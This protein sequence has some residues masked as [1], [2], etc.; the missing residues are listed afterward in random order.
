[1]YFLHILNQR[2]QGVRV[3]RSMPA[4]LRAT[5]SQGDIEY[6]V[7]RVKLDRGRED[8]VPV[9]KGREDW[10]STTLSRK[11]DFAAGYLSR[12][13]VG[14][15]SSKYNSSGTSVSNFIDV[16][17]DF[18]SVKDTDWEKV[19][20]KRELSSLNEKIE[21]AEAES[22]SRRLGLRKTPTTKSALV[23]HELEQMLDFKRRE[24]RRLKSGEDIEQSG[25]LERIRR[26]IQNFKEQVDTLESHL[27]KRQE[28]L[29][30]LQRSIE[31]V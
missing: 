24:L 22:R 25:N 8:D 19:R 15:G 13:G 18:S 26:E 2:H 11:D 14:E 3:P 27:A 7:E 4:S 31:G 21:G 30:N 10:R 5:L 20:L 28:E 17:T 1:M 9:R 29:K 12:L 6:D 23:K 16:G